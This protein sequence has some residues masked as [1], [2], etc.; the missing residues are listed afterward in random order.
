[1]IK[2]KNPFKNNVKFDEKSHSY[3]FWVEN[4]Q[5]YRKM[6][7]S[8]T[9]LIS[10]RNPF[11]KDK[12]SWYKV[13]NYLNWKKLPYI[14]IREK[15]LSI[16]RDDINNEKLIKT[17]LQKEVIKLW[18]RWTQEGIDVH[19]ISEN[20]N[21]FGIEYTGTKYRNHWNAIV[22]YFNGEKINNG[23]KTLWVELRVSHPKL[24]TKLTDPKNPGIGGSI[25]IVMYNEMDKLFKLMDIKVVKSVTYQK[26]KKWRLQLGF[27]HYILNQFKNNNDFPYNCENLEIL[28]IDE[29]LEKNYKVYKFDAKKCEELVKKEF[30]L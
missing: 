25:D 20:W 2:I 29:S 9:G 12:I 26:I 28:R 24:V 18:E 16:H 15:V 22:S 3:Y 11:D 27:Y 23:F 17:A 1:M 4:S 10:K 19:K 7:D 8:V 5:K 21:L 14:E 6:P 30:N 13:N